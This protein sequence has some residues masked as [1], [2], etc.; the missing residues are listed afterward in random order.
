MTDSS[1]APTAVPQPL[2][3][4]VRGLDLPEQH[5]K[6]LT[7]FPDEAGEILL[8]AVD[9]L[10]ERD[11]RAARTLAEALREHAPHAGHRQFATNQLAGM[12]RAEG[13]NA[14]ADQLLEELL[15]PG[16]DR[17]VALLL[18]ED[19]AARGEHDK[20]LHCYN[21][22]CRG[23]LAQP[24]ETVAELN[25]LGLMP[26]LGRARMREL[27]G[28]APDAHDL[29][30]RSTDAYLPP[31]E[32]LADLSGDAPGGNAP[33]RS[34]PTDSADRPGPGQR[35]TP[36]APGRNEPCSCGSGRKYKKC[37]GSPLAR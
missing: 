26:L 23:I 17:G 35:S 9:A 25:R 13:R 32:N 28:M 29:A 33:E 8:D 24:P 31:V 11:P 7:S 2:W 12:L 22:V 27:L 21:V 6:D 4:T 1:P 30:T 5:L 20:A 10:R 19:L 34:R 37:C 16:L 36:P 18:A 15:S 14:E 3:D